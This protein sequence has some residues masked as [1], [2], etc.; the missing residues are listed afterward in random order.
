[1]AHIL[2]VEDDPAVRKMTA[3][4]LRH[5]GHQVHLANNGQEALDYTLTRSPELIITDIMMP[6][7]DGWQLVKRLRAQRR[8]AFTPVLFLT[9]LDSYE[10]RVRGFRLGADDYIT[11]PFGPRD[12]VAR[13]DRMLDPDAVFE[14]T[15]GVVSAR[16]L[17][18]RLERIGMSAVMIML[19]A[20]RKT[21]V[22]TLAHE[23]ETCRVFLLDG[24]AVR[25][26]VTGEPD[27]DSISAVYHALNWTAGSF[28][29][30]E[31]E[32]HGDDEINQPTTYLLIE[33]ARRIDESSDEA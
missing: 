20:E 7:M 22:L 28:Q 4:V 19:E 15:A 12:L 5:A 17:E 16:D 1:M 25:A 6:K 2:V 14:E 23:G 3:T 11:K 26:E 18:G 10:E 32:V 27:L 9:Q 31:C 8:T 13:V 30:V 21:G 33:G 24:T 29:F